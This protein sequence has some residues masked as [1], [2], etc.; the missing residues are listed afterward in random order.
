MK[1][2]DML[3]HVSYHVVHKF[4]IYCTMGVKRVGIH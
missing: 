3:V 2:Q 4:Y 1:K